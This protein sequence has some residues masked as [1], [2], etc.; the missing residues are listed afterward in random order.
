MPSRA[1]RRWTRPLATTGIVLL[2][3]LVGILAL[4]Q[5]PPVATWVV[6]RLVT[7]VPLNPGYHLEV[8]RVSGDWLHRLGLDE[9]RLVRNDR[10]LARVDR[11]KV[12]YD[13]RHLRG[14]E[15]RLRE[16]TVEGARAVARRE[17]DGWDLPNA[18]R[19]SADTTGSGG[20]FTLERLNLRDVELVA[21]LTPDSALRVRGLNLHARDLVIGPQMLLRVDQLNAAV[22]PPGSGRWF[23]VTTRGEVTRGEFRFNPVRIQ[24]EQTDVVGRVLLPRNLD[25]PHLVDRLDVMV[26]TMPLALADLAAVV[27]AVTPEGDLRLEASAEGNAE[28]LVT[29]RLGA[30]LDEATLTLNGAAPLAKGAADYR[31]NA[32]I[33]RFDP[34]RL[35]QAAPSGSLNGKI[36]A[37]LKGSTLSRADGT[38]AFQLVASRLAGTALERLNLHADVRRG[39]AAVRLRGAAEGGAFAVTGRMR[40]FDSVPEYRLTGAASGIPGSDAIARALAG[41]SG[42]PVLDVRFHLAGAGVS[43]TSA[44]LTGR[45]ELTARRRD[46]DSVPL[47]HST[48]ALAGGRL[49]ARP[50]LLVGGGRVTA[51]AVAR[52]ADTVT[53]EV[54]RGTIERV[55]L[56]RLLGDTAVAPLSG[57]FSLAGRGVAPDAAVASLRIELDELRYGTRQV[58]HMAGRARLAS[59]R[60]RLELSG[61]LQGGR[62]AIDAD[63]QPFDSTAAFHLRRASIERV[64]LGTFLGR[65]DLAGPVTLH[66]SGSGRWRGAARSLQ[67]RLTIDPSQLGRV[68]VSAGSFNARLRR[69]RL[70]YDGLLLTNAGALALTGDGRPLAEI[71]SFAIRRGRADS[72]D[73]GTLLGRPDLRTGVNARFTGTMTA[74][75]ADSMEGGLVVEL[76]P[77]NIN[78]AQLTGGRLGLTLESGAVRG[79][80]RLAG[81]DGELGARLSGR[82]GDTK[83]VHTDGS[84]RLER[85]ARWTGRPD[86]G[87][88]LESRFIL[89]AVGDSTGLVSL[90]GTLDAIGGIG[91]VHL[92]TVHLSLRP[93]FGA[94]QVDTIFVRSNV[95]ALDGGGR[96]ALR[97]RG[98]TD[99][100][101]LIGTAADVAPLAA[102]AGADSVTLDSARVALAVSG[103]AGHWRLDGKADVHRILSVGNLAELLT[104]Q[105]N[106]AL[107]S[108]GVS[109]VAGELRV[110]DAAFGKVRIPQAHLSGRYDSLITVE[111]NVAVGDSVRLVAGLRGVVEPDTVR[112]VLHRLDLTEGGRDW[113]LEQPADLMLRPTLIVDGLALH[114]GRRRIILDGTFD[115]HHSSDIALRLTDVDLDM[116]REV[117]LTPIGGRLDGWLRFAG[118]AAGPTLEGSVGL[119]IRRRKG[120]EIGRI[121]TDLAWTSAGLRI[122]ATAAPQKGGR[123]TVNGTLPWR[124]TLAP[125]DTTASVGTARAS[126]DTLALAVRADSFDLGLFEPLL[127]PETAR[128]LRGRLVADT[129]VSGTPDAPRANGTMQVTGV[130]LTLPTMGVSYRGGELIGTMAG[131]EL[132]IDR[133]RLRTGKKEILTAQGNVRLRPLTDPSLDLTAELTKFRISNSSS[134]QSVAS[135]RLRLRGTAG[136]PFLTGRLTMGRTDIIV[137]GGQAAATVEKVELTPEDLRQVAR[138]FGPSVLARADKSPGLVDRFRLDLDLRL[139]RRVWF[140]RRTS[141]KA[142]IELSG[143][144]RLRQE[145]GRPMQFFGRVEPVPG[146]GNLDVYGR[147][148][149]L[150]GGEITI[151]G[152]TDSTRLDVTAEYRVP[153]QGGPEDE[154]VLI[155]V[156]AKGRPDTLTLEFTGDPEMSQDDM[157]SYIL[158]GKPAS[159]NPLAQPAEGGEGAGEMGAK[160]ALSGVSQSLSTAAE[161]GLGLDVFQIHQEGLHG[162]TLTAGR[163]VGSR[164]FLSLHLPIELGGDV[165]QMP[166][167]NL[168]PTFELEYEA[169]RWLRAN[170]RGG[171]VPPRFTLRSRY[172]Y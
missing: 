170:V 122:D 101:R 151:A 145:P 137:G 56:G 14:A 94:I 119:T 27:P 165:Q 123:L 53:Y 13:L 59:G 33:R 15:P 79:D 158:T 69:D 74:G 25:D 134:L 96:I 55:D 161:K 21:E 111:A 116:L 72:L 1:V 110:E 66:A 47:G 48:L 11:L 143:Q 28:G 64:D 81:P 41:K 103:P 60:A 71:P 42:E 19:R 63:A 98:G 130:A 29:A 36:E 24:T 152:P 131:D 75:S 80:L 30:R 73:L 82:L 150:T 100:L 70:T 20:G 88:R 89:D 8:G 114:A 67:G 93:E 108:S 57:R 167:A 84:L 87:G 106:A 112:V 76:L 35:Y 164:V 115:P 22:A 156:A 104:L 10:E 171:N 160:I 91:G 12:G 43:P 117:K 85:L 136:A 102:L 141:P 118:P 169:Q 132:R 17:G 46:G 40:P 45:V 168:G 65:P 120:S 62:L 38:V 86:V 172:A 9:V 127:P 50:E 3:L 140:R 125:A 18:L 126:T 159:D 58:E 49:D 51:H 149:R 109:A 26:K 77:S 163:Y 83:Q 90:G 99:T 78:Q 37:D 162:L 166:G 146:R 148:F 95:A 113:S 138:Q 105:A 31:L 34:S 7:I 68:R 144:I 32:A 147:E 142:D 153:T 2:S 92:Q 4:L 139:P 157:L 44:C 155:E 128:E 97:E 52:L 5:L 23:A 39:S 135:G 129:R 154:G 121:R 54:R 61:A 6:R 124:L 16:L 133:F 107:D